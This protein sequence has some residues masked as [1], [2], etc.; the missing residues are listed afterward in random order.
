M[1]RT[2]EVTT[3]SSEVDVIITDPSVSFWEE[4]LTIICGNGWFSV[5]AKTLLQRLSW[6][7]SPKRSS[8]FKSHANLDMIY[9]YFCI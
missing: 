2:D 8:G 1:L 9:L 5:T 4:S 3:F 7:L 6:S